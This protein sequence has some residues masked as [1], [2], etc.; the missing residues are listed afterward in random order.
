METSWPSG[1]SPCRDDSHPGPLRWNRKPIGHSVL[2]LFET[3]APLDPPAEIMAE[4][5]M[6]LR[7]AALPFETELLAALDDITA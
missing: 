1:Q 5:A 6:L 2:D 3:L 4:G 7:G